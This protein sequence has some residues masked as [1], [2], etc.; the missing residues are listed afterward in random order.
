MGELVA[1]AS[2]DSVF[3]LI[4]AHILEGDVNDSASSLK[5]KARQEQC[6]DI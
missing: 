2:L 3:A 1:Y 6:S 5:R 4:F